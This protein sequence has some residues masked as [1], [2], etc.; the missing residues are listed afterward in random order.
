LSLDGTA[1]IVE[2]SRYS[3][4]FGK[5]SRSSFRSKERQ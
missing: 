2:L 5:L 3:S 4:I 1:G